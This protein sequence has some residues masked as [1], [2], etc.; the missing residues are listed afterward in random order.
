MQTKILG[1]LAS[2][3]MLNDIINK[4][5]KDTPDKYPVYNIYTFDGSTYIE[6]ATTGFSKEHIS[7]TLDRDELVI[8]GEKDNTTSAK[9]YVVRKIAER[10]FIRK[11][12][13]INNVDDIE[14]VMKDGILTIKLITK[15][16]TIS[17]KTINI[18]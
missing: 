8:V 4:M 11:F 6:I 5:L 13:L 10:N 9:D 14:A 18:K 16:E 17:K 1:P 12:K 2:D 15:P 7:I 3:A